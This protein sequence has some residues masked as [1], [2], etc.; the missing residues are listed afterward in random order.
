MQAMILAAGK[1]ARLGMDIPKA[2]LEINGETLINRTVKMLRNINID[3]VILIT[4]YK[5]EFVMR[6]I[7]KS[8]ISV[9]KN[10]SY[11]TSENLVSFKYGLSKLKD[12]FILMHCDLIYEE[13][14]LKRM[15]ESPG[16]IIL[17]YDR[18]SVNAESMKIKLDKN[19]IKGISKDYQITRNTVESIPLM[20]FTAG[21]IPYFQDIVN[22]LMY[23]G[24]FG[25]YFESAL[26]EL[27]HL[28]L[29]NV[30][31]VDLTGLNWM[32]ID[33]QEDY[34]RAVEIFGK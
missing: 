6:A 5:H 21:T 34:R 4:G 20:K 2:L 9:V 13:D 31:C 17:P 23:K 7:D 28:N 30:T 24:E 3:N 1:G 29:F 25:L 18:K 11:E 26:M 27:L 14:F 10:K 33:T 22:N 16:D 19:I 32:E 15:M 8:S 12:D